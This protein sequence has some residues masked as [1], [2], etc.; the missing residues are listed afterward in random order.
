MKAGSATLEAEPS[1]AASSAE[2]TLKRHGK[3]FHFAGKFL[4]QDSFERCARL[5]QFCR[6]LDDLADESPDPSLAARQLEQIEKDLLEANRRD[7]AVADFLDLAGECDFDLEPAVEL[8]RGVKGDLAGVA[9]GHELELKQY[10]YRVAGTVGLMMSGVLGV[11]SPDAFPHAIDLG[12]AMQLTNIAR[13]VSEDARNGRR[14]LPAD[15]F[16]RPPGIET[17]AAFHPAIRG[18]IRE[19][20]QWLLDEADRYYDSGIAGLAYLPWRARLGIL[21]AARL[22][23]SIGREIRSVDFAVWEGR[24]KVALWKKILISTRTA[25]SFCL[26][27]GLRKKPDGHDPELHRHLAGFPL[28]HA[29]IHGQSIS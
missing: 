11:E 29:P 4:P 18:E 28:A 20:V 1:A 17:F 3:S 27:G 19:A 24:A 15:L 25:V 23:Q 9:F 8:I 5:Y 26:Q 10:A 2:G 16:A 12:V 22:Y 7:P 6:F 21:V 14:Y 13:D